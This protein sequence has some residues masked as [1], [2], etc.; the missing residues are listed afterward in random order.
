MAN[1][2]SGLEVVE[3]CTQRVVS[4]RG[5]GTYADVVVLIFILA[6]G[7]LFSDNIAEKINKHTVRQPT[8]HEQCLLGGTRERSVSACVTVLFL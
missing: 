8:R 1:E 4:P 3:L 6:P 7:V 2:R 5:T